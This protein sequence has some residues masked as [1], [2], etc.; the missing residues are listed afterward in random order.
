MLCFTVPAAMFLFRYLSFGTIVSSQRRLLLAELYASN[1]AQILTRSVSGTT[2][3]SPE[4]IRQTLPLP[5]MRCRRFVMIM[6]M[7]PWRVFWVRFLGLSW[8]DVGGI[9]GG[10]WGVL[11]RVSVG[12]LQFFQWAARAGLRALLVV[13]GLSLHV[14]SRHSFPAHGS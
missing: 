12:G 6:M 14:L 2:D 1:T 8:G 10:S 7:L 4:G 5:M 3:T 9:L 11:G 13:C